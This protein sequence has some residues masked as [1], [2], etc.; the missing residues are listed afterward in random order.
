MVQNIWI[1]SRFRDSKFQSLRTNNSTHNMIRRGDVSSSLMRA[2]DVT[3]NNQ[4]D[5]DVKATW[6]FYLINFGNA[7]LSGKSLFCNP[8]SSTSEPKRKFLQTNPSITYY[9]TVPLILDHLVGK[10]T[11]S[12]IAETKALEPLKS[13]HFCISNFQ[14]CQ[15]P[16]EI[17]VVQE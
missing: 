8:F 11:N 6:Q 13:W 5:L 9:W 2:S 10:L 7:N 3:S 15:F 17:W 16:N 12:K 4:T 1:A 14:T